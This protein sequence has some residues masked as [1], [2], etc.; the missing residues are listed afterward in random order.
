MIQILILISVV[1]VQ[2]IEG[3]FLQPLIISKTT[4]LHPVTIML[5]LLV[6]GYFFSVIGMVISTPVIAVL[7]TVFIYFDNKYDLLKFRKN[8]EEVS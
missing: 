7:K 6:F 1:L 5:G 2:F 4:K 3:N 8:K